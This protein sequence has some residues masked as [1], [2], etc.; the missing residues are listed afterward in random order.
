MDDII[1]NQVNNF[2]GGKSCEDF[3]MKHIKNILSRS[4]EVETDGTLRI[5]GNLVVEGDCDTKR[6][7]TT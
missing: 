3:L 6:M 5:K 7:I 4:F 1:V 2:L